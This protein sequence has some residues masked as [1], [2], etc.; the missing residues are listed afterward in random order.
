M[1]SK[2]LR[3]LL[4]S[5]FILLFIA[6]CDC[7]EAEITAFVVTSDTPTGG[8]TVSSNPTFTWHESES[9]TPDQFTIL[10]Q[11]IRNDGGSG[12]T[13]KV[14]GGRTSHIAEFALVAGKKYTWY[15][16]AVA[17]TTKGVDSEEH[18]FYVGPMCSG[19]PIQA[20]ILLS[21]HE[22][23]MIRDVSPLAF[24]WEYDG[25]CLPSSYM[26]QFATD[27]GFTD[28]VDTGVITDHQM[29]VTK[30]FPDCSTLWWRVAA[31]DG[32]SSGPWSIPSAFHLANSSSC[33][34]I[35]DD[36]INTAWLF[37]HVFADDCPRTGFAPVPRSPINP[38]CV[39][40]SSELI[41]HGDGEDSDEP[42][43]SDYVTQLGAG[44]CPSTGLAEG[45]NRFLIQTPGVYCVSIS[46]AQTAR[47]TLASD[48]INLQFG[49][50]TDPVSYST[51]VE[52]T[53]EFG[54][55]T[56]AAVVNFAW[57]KLDN[58]FIMPTLMEAKNCRY[59]PEPDCPI[60]DIPEMGAEVP[61]FGRAAET[62]W[63]LS[64][65]NG[66]PCYIFLPDAEINPELEKLG[67]DWQAEDLPIFQDPGP[68]PEPESEPRE[69]TCSKYATRSE[70]GAHSA[71][72]CFWSPNSNS[73]E[74]P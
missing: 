22:N 68:C 12:R 57:D 5:V 15:M 48:P 61:L 35:E 53:V 40:S 10:I 38:G 60:Y 52:R 36:S 45:E 32:V 19:Q 63:K 59:R 16:F 31:S 13:E 7:D 46:K 21:P 9:C 67:F 30:S 20:P 23:A 4:L 25:G 17:E 71:D 37:A 18:D 42:T 3:W 72:G 70:C 66:T 51:V 6:G 24:N 47:S 28:V 55:G 56:A 50:W 34:Q 41:L 29:E 1:S 8:V 27:I 73:C 44:P 54:P 26:Y 65:L 39:L 43:L 62:D 69:K 14:F 74:G 49:M 58:L 64:A 11:N 2:K 33:P